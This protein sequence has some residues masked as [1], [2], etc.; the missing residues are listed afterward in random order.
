MHNFTSILNDTSASANSYT[1][2]AK[3]SYSVSGTGVSSFA[4][5]KSNGAT[6]IVVWNETSAYPGPSTT[7]TVTLGAAGKVTVYD[8]IVGT[9]ATSTN[10]STSS[11]SLNLIGAPQIVEVAAP[12]APAF[13]VSPANTEVNGT[14]GSITDTN[15]TVWTIGSNQQIY[16]NGTVI[17]SSSGVVTLFWD[18]TTLY[19]LNSVGNWYTQPLDGSAG[20]LQAGAPAGYYVVS[21][22]NTQVNGTTGSITDTNGT[23]WTIGTNQQVYRNGTVVTSSAGVVTLFWTGTALYQLNSAG[24]WYSQ[25]L[26][27]SAGT[28]Q[29]GAPT[30]YVAPAPTAISVSPATAT[31]TT[32]ANTTVSPFTGIVITDSNANQTETA[33]VSLS[34][35]NGTLVDPNSGTDGS[36]SS[37]G[38]LTIT[39][40]AAAVATDLDGLTFTSVAAQATSTTITAA[41]TDTAGQATSTASTV[42]AGYTAPITAISVTPSTASVSTTAGTL[43][44]PFS[45]IVITDGNA[46]Q[47]ETAKVGLNVAN[48]VLTDPNSGSDGSTS[49]GGV[50][51]VTGSATAVATDLDGLAFTPSAGKSTTTSVTASIK[52]TAAETTSTATTVTATYTPPNAVAGYNSP[53]YSDVL[54]PGL[55]AN[56]SVLAA[57]KALQNNSGVSCSAGTISLSTLTITNG[58][59]T[60]C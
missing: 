55:G 60:H 42:N 11:V 40:T 25:P 52:D 46:N 56:E 6:D 54:I 7:A 41:I 38:I 19:Q 30:G 8:P 51:T 20:T 36:T 32:T 50:I 44:Q 48:G 59:V 26:D 9:T 58:I 4:L 45:S 18:G 10:A 22:A 14:T 43:I 13:T 21:P 16:R 5:Q 53:V 12:A 28:L 31:V 39:G 29:A 49:S 47:T 35:A 33:K 1:P 57:I 3:I 23:V 17:A 27:G 24:S 2:T 15:G 37:G 34:A